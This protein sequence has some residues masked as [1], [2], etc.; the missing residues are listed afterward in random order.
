MQRAIA[1]GL[2]AQMDEQ[3]GVAAIVEDH[4]RRAAWLAVGQR[5]LEDAVRVVPVFLE[6]LTLVREYRRTARRNCC[7]GVVLRRI[8]VARRPADI[9]AQRLQRLDEH[10]GLNRHVQ[11]AGDARAAQRLLRREF[12]ANRHE[13]GHLGLGDGDFLAPPVGEAQVGDDEIGEV[14]DVGGGVHASLLVERPGPSGW[15][16]MHS[17]SRD[18]RKVAV[19]RAQLQ[20][21]VDPEPGSMRRKSLESAGFRARQLL[22][23]SSGSGAILPNPVRVRSR[24]RGRRIRAWPAAR[25]PDSTPAGK[26]PPYGRSRA[27]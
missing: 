14:L 22:Q 12:L 15:R 5:P 11:R 21:V 8:D 17:S 7:R 20:W 4:V 27:A 13:A 2:H 26:T 24:G 3:R 25:W 18:R 9:G 6:R 1:L 16:R 23:R 10:R 19:Q